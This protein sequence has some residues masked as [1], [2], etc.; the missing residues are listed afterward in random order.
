[1]NIG[2][3]KMKIVITFIYIFPISKIFRLTD[4]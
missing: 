1:M 4:L 3:F 2:K